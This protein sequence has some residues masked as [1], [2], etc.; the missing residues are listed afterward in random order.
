MKEKNISKWELNKFKG[1]E[2]NKKYR[3]GTRASKAR[4]GKKK[5]GWV[6]RVN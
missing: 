4:E 6:K 5:T 3:V 1:R 2:F